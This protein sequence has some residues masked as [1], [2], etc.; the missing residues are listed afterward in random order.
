VN[1]K[2]IASVS[3]LSV[4]LSSCSMIPAYNKPHI[5]P[6]A[7]WTADAVNV[8]GQQI[9]ADWWTVFGDENLNKLIAEAA[10]QNLDLKVGIE[11][12]NQSRAALKIAG[13]DLLPS[14]EASLGIDK[15]RTNPVEGKTTTDTG[16]SGG[17]SISYDLD[18]FGA[19]RANTAAARATLKSSEYEQKALELTTYG[20][21]TEAYFNLLLTR[22]RIRIAN[23]NLKNSRE[24]LRIVDARLKAGVDS[25]LE[26]A[27]QKVAVSNSE[28]TLTTL[29]QSEVVYNNALSILLGKLPENFGISGADLSKVTVPTIAVGQP[30][31]LVERRPDIAS[32]EQSLMAANANIGVARAAYFPSVTL[33]LSATATGTGFTD[34]LG[35]ALGL[36]SALTAPIFEG[37]RLEGGVEKATS[38]Q[39]QLVA[40][41][42]KTVLTAF[43]EVENALSSVKTVS[44]RETALKTAM[45]EAQKAYDISRKRYEVG[46]IDFAT[47]LDTQA[48]LLTTQDSYAQAM[49]ARLSAS[50]DLVKALGGGWK[51]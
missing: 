22:E 50:L 1:L 13:A 20:D 8:D 7:R 38:S 15:T 24:L 45:E 5:D 41:Y 28:A 36:T 10:T 27:Q 16:L 34:P 9:P 12:V 47:L 37:G 21:I 3:L 46:T 17:L 51:S 30:S 19:N 40:T 11:K 23:E 31:T 32:A 39:R 25:N 14:A 18:L 44:D 33:G 29:V 48:S 42:Q 43:G 35:T 4:L 2:T 49:K 6:P 26:L